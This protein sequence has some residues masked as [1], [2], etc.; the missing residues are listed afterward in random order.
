MPRVR[1]HGGN[2][3]SLRLPVADVAIID[4][5][6]Q[7]QGCSRTEFMRVAA[8]RAAEDAIVEARLFHVGPEAL[9][10]FVAALDAPGRPVRPL[11]EIFTRPAPWKTA[12]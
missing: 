10:A 9:D 8:L 4:R 6:A 5:A 3:V 1:K 2:R 12:D 11:A 7:F